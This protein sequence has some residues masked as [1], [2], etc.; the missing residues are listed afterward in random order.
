MAAQAPLDI[1]RALSNEYPEAEKTFLFGDHEVFRVKKK[2]FVWLGE[3]STESGGTYV[4]V[5]L[6]DTQHFALSLAYVKPAEYGMA[7]WGWVAADFPK[8]KFPADLVRQWI[9]ESYR[10]TA[11]KKLLAMLSD[12]APKAA[13]P[14]PK[15]KPAARKI[16]ARSHR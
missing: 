3:S 13:A 8:G 4:S 12:G 16:A 6:K 5:K 1:V 11:P 10:H 2:V 14:A 9:D 15:K 7:K